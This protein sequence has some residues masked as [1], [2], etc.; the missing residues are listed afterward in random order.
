MTSQEI[1]ELIKLNDGRL[2]ALA[3]GLGFLIWA[4]SAQIA[5]VRKRRAFEES[6]RE[7]AAYVAE[8]SMSAEAAALL[9]AQRLGK[10]PKLD[11]NITAGTESE[12]HPDQR[13][14]RAVSECDVDEDDARELIDQRHQFDD[15][16]WK[17]AVDLVCQGMPVKDAVRLAKVR[18]S[19]PAAEALTA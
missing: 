5:E 11:V 12:L 3:I 8:G 6:R 2:F 9:L 19:G 13:L 10:K 7:I 17:H 1:F 4:I 14:A 15:L 18:K 16:G